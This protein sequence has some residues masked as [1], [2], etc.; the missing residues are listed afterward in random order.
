MKVTW[1]TQPPQY[2]KKCYNATYNKNASFQKNSGE[3]KNKKQDLNAIK[4][5]KS[6]PSKGVEKHLKEEID[7]FMASVTKTESLP[8]DNTL[9]LENFD[10]DDDIHSMD[11]MTHIEDLISDSK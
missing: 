3:C 11:E 1:R 8:R 4:N 7:H 10:Y 5:A 2:Q 9:E 6:H